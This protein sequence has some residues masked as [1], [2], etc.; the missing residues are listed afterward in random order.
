MRTATR[1]MRKG[2]GSLVLQHIIS[3]AKQRDYQRLSLETGVNS[4]FAPAHG[5]T[6]STASND[7]RRSL[8][9]VKIQITCF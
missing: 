6:K 5:L 4:Y 9:I 7:A 2:V 8:T 3:E 1:H